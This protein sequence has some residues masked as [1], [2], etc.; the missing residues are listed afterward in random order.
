MNNEITEMFLCV[1]VK[2]AAVRLATLAKNR[3][4]NKSLDTN[5]AMLT[6]NLQNVNMTHISHTDVGK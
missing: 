5:S 1:F 6:E 3:F 4:Q 2:H